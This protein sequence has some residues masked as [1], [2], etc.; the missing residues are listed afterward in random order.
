MMLTLTEFH[1]LNGNNL[2]FSFLDDLVYF[3]PATA[4]PL[5]A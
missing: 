2:T 4:E 5:L 3:I 1:V